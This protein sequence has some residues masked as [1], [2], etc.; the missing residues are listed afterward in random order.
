MQVLR[1]TYAEWQAQAKKHAEELLSLG[2]I[3]DDADPYDLFEAARAAFDDE[4]TPEEFVEEV[5][6]DDLA[7]R[8]HDALMEKEA[9]EFPEEE[10]EDDDP[11]EFPL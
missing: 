10:F 2:D 4:L 5:F 9:L 7:T 11:D 3:W 1:V 6:A 8:A